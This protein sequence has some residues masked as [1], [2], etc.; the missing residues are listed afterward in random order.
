MNMRIW[1]SVMRAVICIALFFRCDIGNNGGVA[2][3]L[4]GLWEA[5]TGNGKT[6]QL[7]FTGTAFVIREEGIVLSRGNYT[8]KRNMITF[9]TTHRY[10]GTSF[11]P[12]SGDDAEP[13]QAVFTINGNILTL[14]PDGGTEQVY[15]KINGE[16]ADRTPFEGTWEAVIDEY[17][18]LRMIFR[19][20]SFSTKQNSIV[21]S[22]GT[23]SYTD[24]VLTVVLTH[25]YNGSALVKAE[26]ADSS[27][28][29]CG[30]VIQGDTL[31]LSFEGGTKTYTR[32]E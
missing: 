18:T 12:T 6:V 19:G 29:S 21:L 30:Y 26:R 7:Q 1:F 10:N 3:F 27:P 24:T 4:D 11:I 32:K 2:N 15:I 14:V 20:N 28:Q 31:I 25:I 16:G 23:F 9:I 22:K 17:H 5:E 13:A 8:A